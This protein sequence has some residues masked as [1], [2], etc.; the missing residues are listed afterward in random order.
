MQRGA[1]AGAFRTDPV[2][3]PHL[4]RARPAA[5]RRR[6]CR[7]KPRGLVLVTGPTGSG[8]STTL[9]AIIDKINTERHEHI[10]TIED[11][12]EY[13]HPHKICIVNQREVGADTESV[14]DGAQV[15]PAPGPGRRAH[16]R[17]ARPRDDRGGA[18]HRRDRPPRASRTLHTNCGVSDHQPHHR[19]LPAAPA[20]ADPRA[21]LVRARGRA[22]ASRCCRAPTAPGRVL[23]LEVMIPNAAIRNLIR[24]DKIHQIYSQMQVG[25]AK[26]GMQTMNQCSALARHEAADHAGGGA[27][28]T[29]PTPRSCSN[30]IAS[31]RRAGRRP[32]AGERQA[33]RM[34]NDASSSHGKVARAPARSRKGDDGGR[35]ASRRSPTGCARRASPMSKVKK[36]AKDIEIKLP[37]GWGQGVPEKDLV[38][39]TRQFATMI[40]AGLPL[41]QCLDILSTQPPNKN[42]QKVLA[43]RQGAGRAGLD[44]LR[45]A[46]QA[47]EGLRRPLRQPRRGRRGRRHPRHDPA[48][49]RGLHR[50]GDE[51]ASAGQGRDG[52]P[53]SSISVVA[54][55][56]VVVLLC[57]RHPG[58]REDVQGLRRRRAARADPDRH[59]PLERLRRPHRPHHRR[60]SSASSSAFRR[61]CAPRR[62]APAS[63]RSS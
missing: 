5:G 1:V 20:A 3:D 48:P 50:E 63:T 44:L 62:A 28:A 46:A 43:R 16:R 40:D 25:Q 15:R 35:G 22:V 17:D 11:P 37:F 18:D 36:K 8:K 2:Q 21:A 39:F 41:V 38:I 55:I 52:L 53:A 32:A 57:E 42:L 7:K 51:A 23:A 26:F 24:E 60:R 14:Q 10:I 59:R 27:S 4:R 47:P 30:M 19:R 12:I 13:L 29:A 33:V 61:C 54:V 58:L 31:G 56:V 49:P 34:A 6:S 45:R 9:A